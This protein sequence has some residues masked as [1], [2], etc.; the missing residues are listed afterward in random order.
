MDP[1]LETVMLLL[2]HAREDD[3]EYMS[4]VMKH[5]IIYKILP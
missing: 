4:S 2:L 5:T 1:Y 3:T